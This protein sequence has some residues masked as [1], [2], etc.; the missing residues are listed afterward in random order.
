MMLRKF[1]RLAFLVGLTAAFAPSALSAEQAAAP[2]EAVEIPN[3]WDPRARLER[4]SADEIG[5]I[6]FLTSDDF[7]PFSFRDRRGMLI[8]F[9][10]DLVEAICDVL[11]VQCAIQSRPFDTLKAGLA[12]G[13]GNAIIAGLDPEKAAA[14]GLIAGRRLRPRDHRPRPPDRRRL[15]QRPPGIPRPLL[16]K[17]SGKLLPEL[18]RGAG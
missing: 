4:P 14:E 7:P 10:I 15:P 5:S 11:K 6:R 1:L 3:F 8:G 12:D 2:S 17:A 9:D 18:V 13:T 16:P